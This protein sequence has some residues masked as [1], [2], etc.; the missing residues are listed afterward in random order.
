MREDSWITE[1]GGIIITTDYT[2]YTK[3]GL[4][5]FF[6]NAVQLC[7]ALRN[8]ELSA[9][10]SKHPALPKH[11]KIS[12]SD[13]ISDRNLFIFQSPFFNVRSFFSGA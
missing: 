2:G 5:G 8:K 11:K 9:P 3:Y 6:L 13:I 7:A 10:S 1:D 4:R 12:K